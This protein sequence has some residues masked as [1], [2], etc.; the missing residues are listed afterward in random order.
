MS[1]VAAVQLKYLRAQS[2]ADFEVRLAS[3]IQPAVDAGAQLV[4]LPQ[5]VGLALLG[6]AGAGADPLPILRQKGKALIRAFEETCAGQAS[7]FGVWLVPG[8]IIGADGES[9]VAQAYLFAPDGHIAGR[10]RQTHLGALEKAWGLARGDSLDV[11]DT[12]LGC[13]G[14]IVGEDVCYPEVA[15]I[16]ALQGATILV[17]VAALPA[18]FE[19]QVWLASLW[20]EVQANQVLGIEAC[21]VGECLGQTYAGSSAIL[22]PVEMT[23]GGRGVL[24]QSVTI[25]GEQVVAADLDFD[26]LQK[27][28]DG[29]HIFRYFNYDLYARVFPSAYRNTFG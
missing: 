25:D 9:L 16:L 17:H 23:E 27:V 1:K 15:R 10:Q 20:R 5:H 3:A 22:A 12:P 29:Y 14:L 28:V 2:V 24:A 21:L 13:I 7:R 19:E 8:S 26:A 4:V 11:F 18:P 6:A